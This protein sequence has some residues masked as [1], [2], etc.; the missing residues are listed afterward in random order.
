MSPARQREKTAAALRSAC[1]AA[2]ALLALALGAGRADALAPE[3]K[4]VGSFVLPGL[5]QATNGDYADG[6]FQFSA[7]LVLAR[8]YTILVE[9]DDYVEPQDRL[10]SETNEIEINRTS[11]YADA[12]GL[13]L[14][15]L[16]FYSSF[17][18]YRD[19]RL[20]ERNIGYATPAPRETIGDLMVSPFR[21]E[22][23][24]RPTT[25]IPILIPLYL[26][27]TPADKHRL[28]YAPDDSITRDEMGQVSF[29]QM[30][31]VAIGE[32]AFF[33]GVLNNGLS[34]AYGDGW[35]LLGSSALFGLAH[36][37]LPGQ[38]N[39]GTAALFG[40]YL[41]WLHQRNKY[42]IGEGVAIHFWWNFLLTV[43]M[44]AKHEKSDQRQY[45][46]YAYYARF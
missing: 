17:S 6:A 34:S 41:G 29:F 8:Q 46:L 45:V 20:A 11:F 1:V 9:K 24:S 40:L 30:G 35:G 14:L 19:A 27:L 7:A 3:W 33:R 43:S 32:E 26:A 44:L 15:D 22:F 36:A 39:P 12:Y 10:N 25:F 38:A 5:G 2:F 31:G 13:A 28:V 42:E 16:S 18:A 37:G 4:A 21:W 23:L